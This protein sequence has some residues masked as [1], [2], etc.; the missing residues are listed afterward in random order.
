MPLNY[1]TIPEE[2]KWTGQW[3]VAGADANGKYKV[4]CAIGRGT[5]YHADPTDPKRW[6]DFET[7]KDFAEA[8]PPH[9]IGFVLSATDPYV[10]IDLDIKNAQNEP[11][12][13]KWTPQVDVDR[14]YK[15][16][17]AFHSYTE[18][19]AGGQ[20]YHIWLKGHTGKGA[21]RG[22]VEVY[23]QERFIVCTGDAVID[24]PI[25]EN[26]DLLDAL[27]AEMR[28]GEAPVLTLVDN[29]QSE[30]DEVIYERAS[31][32]DNASKFTNL[33]QGLWMDNGYPSQSEADIALLTMLCFYSKSNAQVLRLFRMSALGKRD[34]A[35]KNDYYLGTTLKK[36]RSIAA[37]EE[38]SS[39]VGEKIARA[40]VLRLAGT[41]APV[42]PT[43]PQ[44]APQLIHTLPPIPAPAQPVG[45]QTKHP[46]GSTA[47]PAFAYE[48]GPKDLPDIP[49]GS[50]LSWPPGCVGEIARYIFSI[51]P[52]PIKEVSI[53][54][55]LGMAAGICGRAFNIPQS[56]LNLYVVLVGQ[57][58]IGK[59]ALHGGPA[60]II[61]QLMMS[62]TEASEFI[63]YS[64]YASAPALS[65]AIAANPSFLNIFG[66]FG[67]TLQR[68]A[69]DAHGDAVIQQLRTI[70]TDL[71]QKSGP[72]SVFG[73]LGYSDKDK[74]VAS[75][76]GVAYSMIGETTPGTFYDSLTDSMMAD[77]FL[78]RFTIVEYN[79]TR[80]P[81][82]EVLDTPL[83]PN[84]KEHLSALCRQASFINKSAMASVRV[85]R[86]EEAKEFLSAF[87]KKCDKQIDATNNEGWRQ[88]WNRAHLKVCRIAANL[89]AMD[90]PQFPV[91][92]L[93]QVMW[94][95]DLVMRD[96]KI[97]ERRI[98]SGEVGSS[99]A[100][101]ESKILALA[102][103]YLR[104]K[105]FATYNIPEQMLKD[106]VIPRKVFQISTQRTSCF[107]GHKL[108]QIASMD[109]TIRSLC[110][111]GFLSE[112]AKV[113]TIQKYA[114]HG[115]C[116]RIL[117]L[118][119]GTN[120]MLQAA[121]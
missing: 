92:T 5:L 89:A 64:K 65:K 21:R 3:C 42:P 31:S 72:G 112:V 26:Q 110:D 66:E 29:E 10:C 106:G 54:A 13:S 25:V 68:M 20:G 105:N 77:G 6:A 2:L 111:G 83:S 118:P 102:E 8:N 33:W 49:T 96:I 57:S 121:A 32:A 35:V 48:A 99:D 79:G 56:G 81:L 30:D 14:F 117:Q 109:M 104:D 101:R 27:L 93:E 7:V 115:K 113:E 74:N 108:G 38:I 97:M 53:V 40:L 86:N 44:Q 4:P 58:A 84:L 76:S 98:Q 36:V 88:M 73:G 24:A 120:E 87:D 23:S 60:A 47:I 90:N 45:P 78:S 37:N 50:H 9:G 80:P 62:C 51:S 55:A 59:E 119:V 52:R 17:M 69:G 103:N 41:A 15:I 95:Y 46:I 116:Y 11:D 22:G 70:M 71:Y 67:K 85:E 75:V 100:T 16:I 114:F 28:R 34:K 82:N 63:D 107:T 39:A 91:M 1:D 19:S 61:N 18:R 94:A 43:P 12:Q